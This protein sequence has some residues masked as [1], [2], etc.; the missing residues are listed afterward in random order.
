MTA[1]NVHHL[2]PMK[3]FYIV[4]KIM[5]PPIGDD[6]S[7]LIYWQFKNEGNNIAK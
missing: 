2:I 1:M 6:I 7:E 3:I 4:K 5:C